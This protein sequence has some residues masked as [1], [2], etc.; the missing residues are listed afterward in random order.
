MATGDLLTNHQN[1]ITNLRAV[2]EDTPKDAFRNLII[3]LSGS[4]L[5]QKKIVQ[6][7]IMSLTYNDIM[8]IVE[9]M[10]NST[11]NKYYTNLQWH[12]CSCKPNW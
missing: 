2:H 8:V 3:S 4:C 6:L 12:Y 1:E 9:D 10:N 5:S 7:T 11:T